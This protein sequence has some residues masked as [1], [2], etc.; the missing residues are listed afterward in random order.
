M[1]T[2]ILFLSMLWESSLTLSTTRSNRLLTS[3]W[4]QFSRK[5]VRTPTTNPS[6]DDSD[7]IPWGIELRRRLDYELHLGPGR[8]HGLP[9]PLLLQRLLHHSAHSPYHP[10]FRAV[11]VHH[12]FNA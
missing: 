4:W 6:A 8:R 11:R 12:L 2:I 1:G 7:E 9:H 5:P 10:R 3:G